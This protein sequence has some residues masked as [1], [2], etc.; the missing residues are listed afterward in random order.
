MMTALKAAV[1]IRKRLNFV[2]ETNVVFVKNLL[3]LIFVTFSSQVQAEN[4]LPTELMEAIQSAM[5]THP[6]VLTADSNRMSAKSQ[7]NAGEYPQGEASGD[8]GNVVNLEL[9]HTFAPQLQGMLFYDYGHVQVNH[10]QYGTLQNTRAIGGAGVG[11]NAR[12]FGFAASTYLAWQTQGGTPLSEPSTQ[13]RSPRFWFQ[14][15]H[16]F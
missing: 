14:V 12:L 4:M 1:R 5:N 2:L 7:V 6:E 16:E 10:H 11:V 9:V 8:E 15:S 13:E 3:I